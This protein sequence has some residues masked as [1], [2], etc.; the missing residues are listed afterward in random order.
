[1]EINLTIISGCFAVQSNIKSEDLYHRIAGRELKEKFNIKL[2][3]NVLRYE[4]Y[5]G[6]FEKI[7]KCTEE[8]ETDVM[9][10]QIR[11]EQFLRL[12][13]LV[14]TY[15]DAKGKIK[16]ALTIPFFNSVPPEKHDLL[17]MNLTL[18]AD[19]KE[20]QQ[21]LNKIKIRLNYLAGRIAG[22]KRYAFRKYKGL[23]SDVI[24]FCKEKKI[25]LIIL[26]TGSRPHLIKE[27]KIAWELHY[28]FKAI[29]EKENIPYI[30]LIGETN[31]K[32]ETLFFKNGIH[33]NEAG[34]QRAA[35]L[36]LEK[37]ITILPTL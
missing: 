16:R 4:R 26:G 37:L 30:N 18:P 25:K 11:T 21:I 24:K 8:N 31:E 19:N 20:R 27:N 33:V 36:L 9:L 2:N 7:K 3:V 10:F 13:K 23:V 34:H 29:A 17:Q 15:K 1:M 35:G 28:S 6:C 14:Y 5:T 32:N 12:S 22:N